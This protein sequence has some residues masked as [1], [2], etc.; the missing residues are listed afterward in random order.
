MNMRN[1]LFLG[2]SLV[3]AVSTGCAPGMRVGATAP[4]FTLS[5]LAGKQ[6]SLSQYA[7]KPVVLSYFA[8]W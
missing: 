5:D 6:V 3:L 2:A 1:R 8:T 4:D 7:G